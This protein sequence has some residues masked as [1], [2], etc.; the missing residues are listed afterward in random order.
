MDIEDLFKDSVEEESKEHPMVIPEFG[1]C[2]GESED[3]DEDTKT[4]T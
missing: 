3:H 4:N 1:P 2:G